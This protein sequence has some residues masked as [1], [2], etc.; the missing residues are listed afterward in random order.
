MNHR[1][2]RAQ[3][4]MWEPGYAAQTGRGEFRVRSQ[5]DP[6][7]SYMVRETANG[8]ACGCPDHRYRGADCKHIKV[9]LEVIR[10]NKGYK[11]A[12]FRIMERAKLNLCKFC[13]S[14]RIVKAGMHRNKQQHKCKDCG[15]RFTTNFGFENM[16]HDDRIITRAL[17]MYYTG[18]SVRDIADCL[19][20]EEIKVSYRAV[21]GWVA[22]YSRIASEYLDEIVPRTSDRTMVRADEVWVKVAGEQK[23]L[24]ASMDDDT[25]YWLASEMTH[26]KFQHEA[27]GLVQMTKE[28]IGKSPAH[29]VTDG[30]FAYQKS[31]RKIF[32]KKTNHIRHIHISGKRDRDNNNKMERLNGEIRDR[33]KVFRGLKRFD[34]PIIPGMQTYYNYT[35]KHSSL[36]GKTPAEAALIKVDG[37]NKWKTII[38]NAALRKGGMSP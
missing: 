20:Q 10:K 38:Q 6:A 36:N 7:K 19:E 35:K 15:K 1:A 32:G 16:R 18:M 14:G 13:D 23:Y 8:L 25:R 33:E 27:D 5:T 34:T 2:E 22:K 21:Y 9:V 24:F 37:P 30:L 11:N 4:M 26:S 12:E 29:F 3:E 31:C 17:Q 28:R